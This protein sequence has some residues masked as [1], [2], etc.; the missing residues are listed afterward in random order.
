VTDEQFGAWAVEI[1]RSDRRAFASLFDVM[2]GPL[3]RYAVYIVHDDDVAMDL[4]QDVFAKLWKVRGEIDPDRSLRA[5][6]FQML[7]NLALNHERQKK[8]HQ[9]EPLSDEL[10][11]STHD[12][13][14]DDELDAKTLDRYVRGWIEEMPERRKEAFLLSRRE[15]LS[16]EEIAQL[17]GLAPKT[18]NNHIVLALQH[19][20][21]KLEDYRART[22]TPDP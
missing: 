8:R 6:M 17:M 11:S 1:R 12:Y 2:Y 18:V 5:F 7:R 21:Q 22:G 10:A 3:R 13:N 4:V 15:N 9:T 14:P 20:R 19:I 16:H